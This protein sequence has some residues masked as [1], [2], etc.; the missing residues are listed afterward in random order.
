MRKATALVLAVFLTSPPLNL[1]SGPSK[2]VV[3]GVVSV[4]GRP[5]SGAD[6]TLVDLHSGG[7]QK[8]RSSSGGAFELEVPAGEY[9]VAT[10]SR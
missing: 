6:V 5:L 8:A 9:V 4:D 7:I 3:Q 2:G 10:T 1:I